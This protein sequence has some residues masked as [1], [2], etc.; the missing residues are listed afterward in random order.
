MKILKNALKRGIAS[1]GYELVPEWMA[2]AVP[3]RNHLRNV[4]ALYDV[5]SVIDVGA[6]VGQYGAFLRDMVGYTGEI[7]SFEP[8]SALFARLRARAERDAN[9]RVH[10]RALGT[11][12]TTMSINIMSGSGHNSFLK[13]DPAAIAQT[14]LEYQK[15]NTQIVQ[16]EQ[17][18]VDTLDNFLAETDL[19]NIY[20]KM[21]TQGY[22]RQVLGGGLQSLDKLVGLQTEAAMQ[23]LYLGSTGYQQMTEFVISLGFHLSGFF[24]VNHDVHLRLIECDMVFVKAPGL[25]APTEN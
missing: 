10:N 4:F 25:L 24:P 12:R 9:W 23:K 16:T 8:V 19:R 22:D 21:D 2:G 1:L 18:E 20:L 6:N 3:L 11:E 14:G 5:K 17:V 15:E 13:P 7:V